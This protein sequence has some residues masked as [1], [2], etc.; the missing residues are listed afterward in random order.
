MKYLK[1]FNLFESIS[2]QNML[3]KLTRDIIKFVA[4]NS[5]YDNRV[6]FSFEDWYPRTESLELDIIDNDFYKWLLKNFSGIVFKKNKLRN[7]NGTYAKPFI[8][9]YYNEGFIEDI[10]NI[11]KRNDN[12]YDYVVISMVEDLIRREFHRTIL[13]ELQH[14]YD[15]YVSKG[16]YTMSKKYSDFEKSGKN[17]Y[18]D[19]EDYL[20]LPHEINARFTEA[21]DGLTFNDY[22]KTRENNKM[23]KRVFIEIFNDFKYRMVGYDIL[24]DKIKN[25]LKKRLY[26]IW[27]NFYKENK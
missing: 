13:H 16:G 19:Y 21:V 14:L 4:K 23:T 5:R 1:P 7:S 17:S 12:I 22:L 8:F 24:D 27:D 25:V 18:D 11:I 15:D 10:N 2:S 20:K 6:G 9:I 26:I 3:S